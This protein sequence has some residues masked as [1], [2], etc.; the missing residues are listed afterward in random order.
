MA[1]WKA[2]DVE[3]DE[4]RLH[5]TRTGGA[6]LPIVLA[7]GF[8]DDG[9]CWTPVAE[10]LAAEFDVIMVDARCHRQSDGR[11][12]ASMRWTRPLT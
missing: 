10:L 9:L 2:G 3:V 8:S 1:F 11:S 4:L 7:H 12:R 6:N 5:Y